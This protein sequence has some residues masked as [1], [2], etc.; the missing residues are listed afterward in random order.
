VFESPTYFLFSFAP[1]FFFFFFTFPFLDRLG[2][3]VRTRLDLVRKSRD[4]NLEP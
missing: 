4:L 1:I 2:G 3:H